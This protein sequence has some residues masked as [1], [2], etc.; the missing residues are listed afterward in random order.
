MSISNKQDFEAF[1]L[2]EYQNIAQ[3]HFKSIETISTFFRY[4]LLIMSIPISAIAILS[5]VSSTKIGLSTIISKYNIFISIVLFCISFIGLGIFS[6]VTNL[7]LDAI[8]YA[9][10]VNG[11]RKYF[12]D[13]SDIDINLKI[14]MRA[15][16][17][18]PYLPLYYEKSLFLPVVFV[19][20]LMNSLYFFIALGV[21]VFEKLKNSQAFAYSNGNILDKCFSLILDNLMIVILSAFFLLAHFFIYHYL[22]RHREAGYLK[23]SII[24]IDIDGVLNNHRQHFCNLLLKN[25]NKHLDPED[26]F[27][28]PVHEN[29]S[30]EI[31]RDDER[32]VFNDPSYWM[33]MPVIDKS[34]GD[35][36]RSIKNKM[37][38]NYDNSKKQKTNKTFAKLKIRKLI[39]GVYEEDNPC[40]I[41]GDIYLDLDDVECARLLISD[42]KNRFI[43][44]SDIYTSRDGGYRNFILKLEKI[45][46]NLSNIKKSMI[47]TNNMIFKKNK[48]L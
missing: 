22:S 18:S 39:D 29:K 11:I 20:A 5:Q 21:L 23:S 42:S 8:L 6:Y 9:R 17:Q 37:K 28:M 16:P 34:L 31:S 44:Y 1:L 24:G 13:G 19:F 35:I 15:L 25:K 43:L 46:S 3:A 12:Y 36:L 2:S 48:K 41:I 38:L 14:R 10:V 47:E 40:I 45:I 7:R 27:L 32:A 4:Y 33:D 26:I 30:L